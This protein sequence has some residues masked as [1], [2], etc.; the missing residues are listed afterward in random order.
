MNPIAF[1]IFHLWWSP[2]AHDPVSL[3]SNIK[4][5]RER[6]K[7]KVFYTHYEYGIQSGMRFVALFCLL[8]HESRRYSFSALWLIVYSSLEPANAVKHAVWPSFRTPRPIKQGF[9]FQSLIIYIH[10]PHPTREE[11]AGKFINMAHTQITPHLHHSLCMLHAVCCDSSSTHTHAQ[12]TTQSNPQ[13][14]RL[15]FHAIKTTPHNNS[16]N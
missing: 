6:E 9:S 4:K 7:M 8:T 11:R 12:Y 16:N 1:N 10:H 5:E 15:E 2:A 3:N 14:V 13:L